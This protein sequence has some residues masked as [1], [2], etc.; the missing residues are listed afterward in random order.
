LTLDDGAIGCHE[1]CVTYY[2]ST[3]PKIPEERRSQFSDCVISS[4]QLTVTGQFTLMAGRGSV[5][6]NH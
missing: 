2:Q 6:R 4:M 5:P 1:T 3:L